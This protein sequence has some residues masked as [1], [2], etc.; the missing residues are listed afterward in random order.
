MGDDAED[1][2]KTSIECH[3][4]I[5]HLSR[6]FFYFF[7]HPNFYPRITLALPPSLPPCSSSD[8]GSHSGPLLPPPHYGTCLHFYREKNSAF[9]SLVDSRGRLCLPTLLGVLS[10]DL[11]FAFL[12]INSKSHHGGNRTQGP[13]LVA[14]EGNH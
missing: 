6:D 14:F 10:V 9:S 5:R 12:Q 3:C 8:P 4:P 7:P 11:F 2:K 13:M 1:S